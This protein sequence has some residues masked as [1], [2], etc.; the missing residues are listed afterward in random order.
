VQGDNVLSRS[1]FF[2]PCAVR[3][4]FVLAVFGWGVGFYGP[5]IYL[6]EV[7]G[8]TG[9]ALSLVS[10]AVTLHFL[11]GAIVIANLPRLYAR[12]GLP[13]TTACGAALTALGVLGWALAAQPWQLLV[14]A[15][16]TGAGWVTMGA[17]AINSVVSPWYARDRPSP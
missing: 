11:F 12:V 7:I 9:W 8:R 16:A 4:A 13:A 1:R 15:L 2:G 17:V 10:S 14:A 3:S 6:A 5:S